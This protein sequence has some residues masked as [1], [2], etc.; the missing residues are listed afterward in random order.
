MACGIVV[1]ELAPLLKDKWT[2]PPVVVVDAGLNNAVALCG[3][4]HGANELAQ[5]LAQMGIHP[6]ITTA[7]EVLG[8]PSVEGIAQ[9]LD[10]EIVNK[11]S[12]RVVSSYLLKSDLPVMELHGPKVVMVDP[13]VTVLQRKADF[14]RNGVIVGIGARRNVRP[15][16]VIDAVNEALAEC[17]LALSDVELFASAQ[18]KK[19]EPGLIEAMNRIGGHIVFIPTEVINSIH[20]PSESKAERLGLTGVCEPAALALSREHK[21]IMRKKVYDNITIAIAR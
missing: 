2:D 21:L 4:H 14:R 9:V 11:D 17:G 6:V 20:P 10:C 8:R 19:H 1:R 18:I 13:D 5:R 7:T 12:T 3:G 16:S 15:G